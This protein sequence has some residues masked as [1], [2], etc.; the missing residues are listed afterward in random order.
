M[1]ELVK[2]YLDLVTEE[3]TTVI[4]YS[5]AGRLGAIT[6]RYASVLHAPPGKTPR[7]SSA[8][9]GVLAPSEEGGRVAW[10]HPRLRVGG[11]WTP[12]GPALHQSL[13]QTPRGD[14]DWRC[15]A[16]HARAEVRL[17]EQRLAGVGYAECL[18]LTL[19]PWHLPFRKL[20]WGRYASGAHALV[21]ILWQDGM[22]RRWIWLDGTAQPAARLTAEGVTGLDGGGSLA[23]GP[24]RVLRDR[25]VIG[26]VGRSLPGALRRRLGPLAGMEEHKCV[27]E[28]TLSLPEGRTERGWAIHEEVRW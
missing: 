2:W 23:F 13:L 21:W 4:A 5:A 28:S 17:G 20:S 9:S 18:R 15:V 10:S 6:F 12:L 11:T 25:Q 24:S 1:F 3:G 19:A 16:P 22:E 26:A 14:V 7:E 27:A 8:I